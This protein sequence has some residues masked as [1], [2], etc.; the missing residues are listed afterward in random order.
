MLNIVLGLDGVIV[1]IELDEYIDLSVLLDGIYVQVVVYF[2]YFS[3]VLVMCK[4]LL[5][6]ISWVYYFYFDY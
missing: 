2:D 4:V 1:I 3:Y 6:M 5:C